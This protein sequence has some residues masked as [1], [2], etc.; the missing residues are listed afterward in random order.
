MFEK[1]NTKIKKETEINMSPV[2]MAWFEDTQAWVTVWAGIL[3]E[4]PAP[5]AACTKLQQWY[6]S[7]DKTAIFQALHLNAVNVHHKTATKY[8]SKFN[9]RLAQRSFMSRLLWSAKRQNK[10]ILKS[11]PCRYHM[12]KMLTSLA[13]LLVFTSCITV[14]TITQPI[15]SGKQKDIHQ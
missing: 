4:M 6:Y 13:R 12:Y 11:E 5:R 2:V 3:F 14:P 15:L 7:Y 1:E 10:P 8:N 9:D